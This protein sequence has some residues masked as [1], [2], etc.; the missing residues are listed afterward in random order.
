MIPEI[1]I[2]KISLYNSTGLRDI[3]K[4]RL[5]INSLMVLFRFTNGKCIRLLHIMQE[6]L[7]YHDRWRGRIE[8]KVKGCCRINAW[9]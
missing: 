2:N 6:T 9:G 8:R 7:I 4:S 1:L 5:K 3:F